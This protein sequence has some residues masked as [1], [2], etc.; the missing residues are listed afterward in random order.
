MFKRI[1]SIIL[2]IVLILTG[3]LAITQSEKTHA[4]IVS[5]NSYTNG[6]VAFCPNAHGAYTSPSL[7]ITEY[8]TD[9]VDVIGDVIWY[10][11]E[12][13][14]YQYCTICGHSNHFSYRTVSSSIND[15]GING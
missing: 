3:S 4:Y 7:Y 2:C 15:G 11:H 14:V 1:I 6:Y 10:Y 5:T 12:V 13:E 8:V 9:T